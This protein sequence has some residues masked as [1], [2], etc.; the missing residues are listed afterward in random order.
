MQCSASGSVRSA[1]SLAVWGHY[2]RDSIADF[3]VLPEA[4]ERFGG[5]LVSRHVACSQ[6][7]QIAASAHRVKTPGSARTP[8]VLFRYQVEGETEYHV[9]KQRIS[10]KAGEGV[11][12]DPRKPLSMR[13]PRQFRTITLKIPRDL[14]QDGIALPIE[15]MPQSLLRG[16]S[17]APLIIEYLRHFSSV[18][19]LDA[20][21]QERMLASFLDL[22]DGAHRADP[23]L[24][25]G[26]YAGLWQEIDAYLTT[27]APDPGLA[28]RDVAKAHAVSV[29]LLQ[30]V[31]QE[32]A[33]TF[34]RVL[35]GKRLDLARSLLLSGARDRISDVAYASGF[36]DLSY[37]NRCYKRMFGEAPRHS[38]QPCRVRR[39]GG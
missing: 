32:Q 24:S 12:I 23:L 30:L 37:F 19:I 22:F 34:S 11:I 20:R 26:R 4:S 3:E 21:A 18:D 15:D 35:L 13:F 25:Q 39:T 2:I 6:V 33:T 10:T 31:F 29:R 16:R 1:D 9:D 17:T 5:H 14:C 7:V 8:F 28:I 36:N 38:L 27:R